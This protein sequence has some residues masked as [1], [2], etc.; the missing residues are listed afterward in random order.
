M[1]TTVHLNVKALGA[2]KASACNLVEEGAVP[3]ELKDGVVS[4]P[5]RARGLAT[6]RLY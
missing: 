6:V 1:E 4:V 5:L 2:V 3:L